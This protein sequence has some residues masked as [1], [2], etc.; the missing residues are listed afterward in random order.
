MAEIADADAAE[1]ADV[2]QD[3]DAVQD[4]DAAEDADVVQDADAVQGADADSVDAPSL[5]ALL[6]AGYIGN[7]SYIKLKFQTK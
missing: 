5:L 2:A 4:A 6:Q 7:Y 3:A 1:D